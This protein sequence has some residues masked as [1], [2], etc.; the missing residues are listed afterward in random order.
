MPKNGLVL[1][2]GAIPQNKIRGSE[3][4][5]YYRIDP[6]VRITTFRYFCSNKFILDP[7]ED[8]VTEKETYGLVVVGRKR[9]TIGQV[10]GIN[11]T[12]IKEFKSGI[13]SKH[14]QGGQSQKRF[15][16][17][18]REKEKRFYRK[19]STKINSIFLSKD[20]TGIFI[21]GSGDSKKRF[22]SD[23][24]LDY[25]LAS[26]VLKIIDTSYDG[27]LEGIRD[28]MHK[29]KDDMRNVRYVRELKILERLK[30]ILVKDI[31]SIVYGLNEV[32]I[33]LTNGLVDYLIISENFDKIAKII[34]LARAQGTE[35]FQISSKTEGEELLMSFG[36]IVGILRYKH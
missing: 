14:N 7:L 10:K 19:I 1:F 2:S 6:P 12:L 3:K 15:E 17:L 24:K 33:A 27:G 4:I 30:N 5:E 11:L 20:I 36:G 16:R 28:L 32:K 25:R 18:L 13:P 9:A 34:K 31:D 29:A 26:K 22:I 21:G 35:F 8:M 23:S